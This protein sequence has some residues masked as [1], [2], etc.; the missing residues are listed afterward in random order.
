MTGNLVRIQLREHSEL[1]G[2]GEG[3][4][5]AACQ[6]FFPPYLLGTLS[7]A[8]HSIEFISADGLA[9]ASFL[10]LDFDPPYLGEKQKFSFLKIFINH[11][12][13]NC[14]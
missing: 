14:R 6:G 4:T 13:E 7:L 2:G 9:T 10:F 8:Y 3:E 12:C 5:A 11:S 1:K